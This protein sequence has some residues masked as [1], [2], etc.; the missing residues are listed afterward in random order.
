MEFSRG[1]LRA[2]RDA[3]EVSR[4]SKIVTVTVLRSEVDKTMKRDDGKTVGL[5]FEGRGTAPEVVP[6][7][8]SMA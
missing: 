7:R 3:P 5:P 1:G 2:E 4:A 6:L 8:G